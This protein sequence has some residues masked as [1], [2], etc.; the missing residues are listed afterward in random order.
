[1]TSELIATTIS[2]T[3]IVGNLCHLLYKYY[4]RKKALQKLIQ[5][6]MRDYFLMEWDYMESHRAMLRKACQKNVKAELHNED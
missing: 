6:F 2:V 1:M 4:R 3:V 5:R